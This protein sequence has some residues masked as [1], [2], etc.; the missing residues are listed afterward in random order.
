V[1]E[2]RLSL[3]GAI[4]LSLIVATGG[5]VALRH[6]AKFLP[7]A[8]PTARSL[9]D[10]PV[11]RVGGLAIWAGFISAALLSPPVAAVATPIWIATWC[12]V[13]AVSLIDDWRGVHPLTRLAVHAVAAMA[14]AAALCGPMATAASTLWWVV[15]FVLMTL[16]MIWSANLFNFMDGN[17]GLAA[18]T[19]LL[20][21]A[22]Y[23]IAA[24]FAGA[25]AQGYG[26]L[27]AATLPFLV[28][29]LPPARAFMGD[30]GAVPL[31]FLAAL[32]GLAGWRA[33]VWPGWF[34]LLAFLPFLADATTTLARRFWR[35]E[36]VWEAHR[37]HYYQRLNQLGAQH[38]GT[39]A[40]YG[41][42]SAGTAATA[43]VVLALRPAAGW[44]AVAVWTTIIAALFAGIDY[45]WSRKRLPS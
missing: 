20:G 30:V 17:D 1:D 28:V 3:S 34:P 13:S 27:A 21:F 32:F 24:S 23:G 38:R 7:H 31:G 42:L 40:V 5:V 2:F 41:G 6:W 12:S 36:R 18:I 15:Q 45:H 29:N 25:S 37:T 26:A 33:G 39:L 22:A 9:H 35:G 16:A 10:R 11:L 43:L 4:L 44:W 8:N 14:G 19:A